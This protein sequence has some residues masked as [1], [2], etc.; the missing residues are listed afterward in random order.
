MVA[1]KYLMDRNKEKFK[2]EL[3]PMKNQDLISAYSFSLSIMA[4]L[5]DYD[6]HLTTD[7]G[8]QLVTPAITLCISVPLVS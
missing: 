2:K 1:L 8:R 4:L 3:I 7:S 5:E 6:R